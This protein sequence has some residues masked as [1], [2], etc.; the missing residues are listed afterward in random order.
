LLTLLFAFAF[1]GVVAGLYWLVNAIRGGGQ[2][3][4][5]AVVPNP[6]AKAGAN[7]NPFQKYVEL[8]GVR[9]A[10]DPKRKDAILVRF[11]LV[12]HADTQIPGL[13]ANVTIWEQPHKSGDDP[14]GTCTFTT[15]MEPLES[16]ELSV[17][18]T[19]KL[20]IYELPDWQ[21]LS[22]ELQ[23]TAPGGADSGGSAA[24]R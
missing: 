12:N 22:P 7:A 2:T 6:A 23:V 11:V 13:T 14:Q 20:R 9:F 18:L 3:S 5:V 24:P 4:S 8:S 10:E 19:T 15:N 17:P 1:V 16:K 21:Y